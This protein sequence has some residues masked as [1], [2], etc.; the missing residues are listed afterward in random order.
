V[1]WIFWTILA[2]IGVA[3]VV[4]S[5]VVWWTRRHGDAELPESVANLLPSE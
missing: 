4:A 2:L 3:I 5:G 1:T